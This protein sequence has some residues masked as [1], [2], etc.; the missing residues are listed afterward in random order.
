MVERLSARMDYCLCRAFRTDS[1]TADL[2]DPPEQPTDQTAIL[3]VIPSVK[4]TTLEKISEFSVL[5]VD[6][7]KCHKLHFSSMIIIRHLS[8]F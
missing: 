8:G 5:S 3:R 2:T 1:N 7:K 6:K 4:A